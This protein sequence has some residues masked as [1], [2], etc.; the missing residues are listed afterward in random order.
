MLRPHAAGDSDW[1]LL[2]VLGTTAVELVALHFV[3]A[4]L[5]LLAGDVERNPGPGTGE[6]SIDERTTI[7]NYYI[8]YLGGRGGRVRRRKWMERE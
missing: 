5:L 8:L 3:I 7:E 6:D 4:S 1:S 2:L